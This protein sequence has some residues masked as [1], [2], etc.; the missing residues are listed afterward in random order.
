M[1]ETYGQVLKKNRSVVF[2]PDVVFKSV[3]QGGSAGGLL[4]AVTA[5]VVRL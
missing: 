4:Q 3:G 1:L 5:L 2:A